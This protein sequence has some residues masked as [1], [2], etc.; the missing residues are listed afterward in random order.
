MAEALEP[1][2]GLLHR[3]K[4]SVSRHRGSENSG[5]RVVREPKNAEIECD[6]TSVPI[7]SNPH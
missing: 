4:D 5:L 1:L 7:I 3:V 2:R 6:S